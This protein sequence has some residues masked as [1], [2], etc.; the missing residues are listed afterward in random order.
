LNQA[1]N[2]AREDPG[3]LLS[4]KEKVLQNNHH[5][6]DLLNE[7]DFQEIADQLESLQ[8]IV[9]VIVEGFLLFCDEK[10]CANLDNKFFVTA[11]KQVLKTRRESRP[12]YVTLQG[13]V[14]RELEGDL[15]AKRNNRLLG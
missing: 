1:I 3:R 13:K 5:G 8:D 10:V 9:F 11:S 7:Q 2:E 6:S 12:G 15:Y 14:N 4:G